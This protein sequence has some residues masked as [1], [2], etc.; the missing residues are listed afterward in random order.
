[1]PRKK[2]SNYRAAVETLREKHSDKLES[3]F[4]EMYAITQNHEAED[5]DRVNAA[6]T[7]VSI[8]GV[9]KPPTM[10]KEP[11]KPSE[12]KKDKPTLSKE[13]NAILDDILGKL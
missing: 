4:T 7:C 12:I 3:I 5:K 9:P 2:D 6:K 1:M 13:H 11:D 8:L 10:A